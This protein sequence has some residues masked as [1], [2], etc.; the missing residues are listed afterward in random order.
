MAR[1][2]GLIGQAT[3]PR[4]VCAQ[5]HLF[6]LELAPGEKKD[7]GAEWCLPDGGG[8]GTGQHCSLND[9]DGDGELSVESVGPL[10]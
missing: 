1:G 7:P 3:V 5:L 8:Q 9:G 4:A 6:R 2:E 10:R